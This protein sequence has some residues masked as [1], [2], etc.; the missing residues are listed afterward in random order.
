M[1]TFPCVFEMCCIQGTK[2]AVKKYAWGD[3]GRH[4]REE[5]MFKGC[6]WIGGSQEGVS[7][8]RTSIL[9]YGGLQQQDFLGKTC[10][11]FLVPR[12]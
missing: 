3:G 6:R 5:R 9:K 2:G 11:R 1:E 8:G 12:N 4:H 10:V 7:L